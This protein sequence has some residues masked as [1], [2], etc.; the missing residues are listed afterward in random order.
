M[1][2]LHATPKPAEQRPGAQARAKLTRMEQMK[3]SGVAVQM[4]LNPAPHIVNWLIEAGLRGPE[5]ALSWGEINAWQAGTG[6]QLD[7]FETRLIHKLSVEYVAMGRK[8]EEESCPAP[9][10]ASVSVA[11]RSVSEAK[12]R[13]VLG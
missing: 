9:W 3:A 11:D 10:A 5:G 6:Q 7:A 12:L 1:A 8:A 2:W 13:S 4:P